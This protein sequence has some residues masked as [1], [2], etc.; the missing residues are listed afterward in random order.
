M[1][2]PVRF[3]RQ[4]LD[5]CLVSAQ[6]TLC[7]VL[8]CVQLSE[9]VVC[10][11]HWCCPYILAGVWTVFAGWREQED[12]PQAVDIHQSCAG[13]HAVGVCSWHQSRQASWRWDEGI[14]HIWRW[15]QVQS[16]V[17]PHQSHEEQ[18]C[19]L[20]VG[21]IMRGTRHEKFSLAVCVLPAY[22]MILSCVLGDTWFS[23]HVSFGARNV[24]LGSAL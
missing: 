17:N 2:V 21:D 9:S 7:S 3:L 1:R 24:A 23:H 6:P 16:D 15:R 12:M 19:L 11:L 14:L 13:P 10:W 8:Y 4:N 18:V 5:V 20:S 22:L